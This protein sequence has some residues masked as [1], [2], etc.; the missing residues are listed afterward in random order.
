LA[1]DL[2]HRLPRLRRDL[3]S[4]PDLD[5]AALGG[6]NTLLTDLVTLVADELLPAAL[7]G[8]WMSGQIATL[9][10]VR[11]AAQDAALSLVALRGRDTR[12]NRKKLAQ[13]VTE[14]LTVLRQLPSIRGL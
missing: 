9:R 12:T 5:R 13:D 3:L 1:G 11:D 7:A 4:E 10:T 2:T 6:T 8:G 14:L